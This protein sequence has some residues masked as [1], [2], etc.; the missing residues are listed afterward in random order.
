VPGAAAIFG[1]VLQ[2]VRR[3]VDM[4]YRGVC[5]QHAEK[6]GGMY[7]LSFVDVSLVNQMERRIIEC[8]SSHG[9][10]TPDAH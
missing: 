7:G 8:R 10:T 6:T 3:T 5:M 9:T 2:R 4:T 1:D